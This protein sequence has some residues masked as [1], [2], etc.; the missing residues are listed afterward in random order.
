MLKRRFGLSMAALLMATACGGSTTSSSPAASVVTP[1]STPAASGSEA[2][3]PSASAGAGEHRL[4][5]SSYVAEPA[6]R[7]AT[8]WSSPSGRFRATSTSTMPRPTRTSKRRRRRCS[9]WS[10][11]PSDLKYVPDLATNVPLV[12]NGGVVVNGTKMDVTWK[13]HDGGKW[14][15]GSPMTCADLEATWKWIM[16]PANGAWPAAYARLRGHRL[17]E[18]EDGLRV[19]RC[20]SRRSTRA[21]SACSRRCCRPIHLDGPGQGRAD[22][23]LPADRP[24]GGRLQRSV[25]PDRS[26]RPARRSATT[27]TRTTGPSAAARRRASST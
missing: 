15:D 5:G 18:G 12:S 22:Q 24:R 23:A 25:H 20:T 2:A 7:K 14:S 9:A 10:T 8:P 17:V 13:L 19:R 26:S 11:P 16:D 27:S 6:P 21:T 4:T 1:T 3:S